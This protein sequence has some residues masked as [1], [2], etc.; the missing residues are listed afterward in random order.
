MSNMKFCPHCGFPL[1]DCFKFC[2]ECGKT[3]T[4]GQG[5]ASTGSNSP[6]NPMLPAKAA[7]PAGEKNGNP[8]NS[9]KQGNT[10]NEAGRRKNLHR[11][12]NISRIP[13]YIRQQLIYGEELVYL[14]KIHWKIWIPAGIWFGAVAGLGTI[15]PSLHKTPQE[16]SYALIVFL[17]FLLVFIY[18]F[19]RAMI[20]HVCTCLAVTNKRVICKFGFI[21][22]ST[23]E[24]NLDKVEGVNLE[25]S[26]WGRIFDCSTVIVSG[27]GSSH[28]PVPNIID[29]KEFKQALLSESEIYKSQK[30]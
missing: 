5:P 10:Q 12:E 27:T 15:L 4:P 18:Y 14:C 28:A 3:L 25:Q 17:A 2:P 1:S 16:F 21:R 26:F 9:N 23:F 22:R 29:A 8:G 19:C 13:Q 11:Q 24:I 6:A 30:K 7:A 20:E